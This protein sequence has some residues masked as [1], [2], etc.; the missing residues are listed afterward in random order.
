MRR[1]S[2]PSVSD[3]TQISFRSQ[4]SRTDTASFLS[5][6]TAAGTSRRSSKQWKVSDLQLHL[7]T[8]EGH[9]NGGELPAEVVFHGRVPFGRYHEVLATASIVAIPTHVMAYPSGQTVALEA[10]RQGLV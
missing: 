2:R 3:T 10:A 8:D 7:Y 6:P 5:G 9:L 4:H 1:E